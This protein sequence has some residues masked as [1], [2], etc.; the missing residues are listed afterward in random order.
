V[1]QQ[2]RL[3][4]VIGVRLTTGHHAVLFPD[5]PEAESVRILGT[6]P[7]AS[8]GMRHRATDPLRA[9]SCLRRHHATPANA[10]ASPPGEA[11]RR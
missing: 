4:V 10:I 6:F 5:R 1:P 9:R 8:A 2:I 7:Q 3:L 11:L